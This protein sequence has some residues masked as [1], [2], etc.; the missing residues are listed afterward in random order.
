MK[1]SKVIHRSE[2]RIRVDFPYNQ[3][4]MSRLK[5]IDDA[6]WSKTMGAWHVPYTKEAFNKL[7]S[8][9]SE[10]NFETSE[11][12]EGAKNNFAAETKQEKDIASENK[13]A[14]QETL[15]KIEPIKINRQKTIVIDIT[16]RNIY[17]KMPKND[18][19]VLF[20]R[21]FRYTFWDS[22]NFCWVL[23]N[24]K[25]NADQIKSHF[26]DRNP[27]IIEHSPIQDKIS[28][29]KHAFTKNEFLV[30]NYSH[31]VLK[32]FFSYNKDIVT[33]LKKIPLCNWNN[34]EHCWTV[35]FSDKF[36]TEVKQIAHQY[37]LDF[38]YKEEVKSKIKARTSR[39]DIENYKKCPDEYIAKLKEL[40]YSENTL[41][42]YRNMFEEFINYFP[43]TEP[44]DITDEMIVE[45]LRYLVNV[46]NISG[47]YQNQSINSIKFYYER[48]LGGQRKVYTIERPRKEK[49]LPEVLSEEE[50]TAIL[51]ATENL[52]HKAIFMTIY[53]AGLRIGELINLKIK[54]IDSERM[55]IRV[56]QAKGKKDRYTILSEK[57]LEIL[58]KYVSEYRPKVWL[59]EGIKGERYS[60]SSIQ[61]NLKIAVDKT[62]IRKRVTVHTLRHSFA[63]HLLES[64]TD[65][66]YIQSLLGHS[67]GKTT[68][69]YTHITTKGFD[70]IKSPL[71]KLKIK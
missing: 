45:F 19:D 27:E 18:S 16:H 69:I 70:Q 61:A 62:G 30:L 1:V 50:I 17:I 60:T 39:Y 40:R 7:K 44:G 2:W 59:F 9:F 15:Q 5:L 68:E 28:E 71:D 46:R 24:Y 57:T 21:K 41:A 3:E 53:S 54:D 10:L 38:I 36:L 65:I 37:S 14:L 23:P 47:S 32:L 51:N 42:T 25:N 11:N 56:E 26:K 49:Y 58:R 33:D 48:V 64:G 12:P 13:T 43:E 6:K 55:Q 22:V 8:L 4:M 52:K 66:R 35:P 34:D 29:T 63:T 20:L 67:N 31:R